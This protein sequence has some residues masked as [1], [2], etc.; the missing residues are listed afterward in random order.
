MHTS[1]KSYKIMIPFSSNKPVNYHHVQIQD[2]FLQSHANLI[3]SVVDYKL[4]SLVLHSKIEI[5]T[6]WFSPMIG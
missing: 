6:Q 2:L 5:D 4:Y 1:V 3:E